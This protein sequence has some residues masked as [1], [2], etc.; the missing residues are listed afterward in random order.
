MK[1][2]KKLLSLVL[3]MM[4]VLAMGSTV[5]ASGPNE[6]EP[7]P[8]NG[9]I[10]IENAIPGQSYSIY[11]VF[12][13]SYSEENKAYSYTVNN[14]WLGFV[15]G[16][17]AA[18]V[19]V[20]TIGTNNYVTWKADKNTDKDAADFAK[21]ALAYAKGNMISAVGTETAD[22]E[23]ET[24]T[25]EFT[26]L[27]LGYYLVD[28]STG[29]LC[30]LNT[31]TPDATIQEKNEK[32]TV[33]K[34]VEE[35]T[36]SVGD[37]LHYT[38]KINVKSGSEKYILHDKMSEGLTFNADS[39]KVTLLDPNVTDLTAGAPVDAD[40]YT[41][42]TETDDDD[43]FDVVFNEAYCETLAPNSTLVI[44]YTAEINEGALIE[45]KVN[46]TVRLD[47]GENN[48]TEDKTVE[49]KLFDLGI[50]KVD[51]RD[52]KGLAG[53]VFTLSKELSLAD[54]SDT[55][56]KVGVTFAYNDES[57]C[58]AATGTGA[59]S[60]INVESDGS[61]KLKGLGAGTYYLHEVKAPDGYNALKEDIKIVI[62]ENGNVTVVSK[63]LDE[64]GVEMDEVETVTTVTVQNMTGAELPSTGG[65][66]TTIFYVLGG[67]LVVGAGIMLVVKK[68]MSSEK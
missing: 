47:F 36:A 67:I 52:N 45:D 4:L 49:T 62:N 35:P 58:Y 64:N 3:A 37:E 22:G 53:A 46:N 42:L 13:L 12:D 10:K 39:L 65:I 1:R 56:E 66:G 9:S 5:M 25:V 40:K 48:R 7:V 17:G 6:E 18:Y 21:L 31:A 68:R 38:V 30:S 54:G 20:E 28:S 16:E 8:T 34:E 24:T 59:A 15:T 33:E 23:G 55:A 63:K 19:T 14:D 26:G 57:K 51:G 11:R 32:T 60:E 50:Q 44:T 43:T 29:A 61:L 41:L 27:G 2:V